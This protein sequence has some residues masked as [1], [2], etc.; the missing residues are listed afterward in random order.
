MKINATKTNLDAILHLR[1]LFLQENNFQIRYNACHQRGWTDSYIITFHE[2]AI[3]YGSVKGKN[4]LKDR[5][6]IFEFYIIPTFRNLSSISFLALLNSSGAGFIECQ[7]NEKVLTSLLY[8]MG[9]NIS[10]PV[11]LF[12]DD[13]CTS[14]APDNINFRKRRE[15]DI[16]FEHKA[17][18]AGEYVLEQNNEIV[19]S[20]GFLLHY[21]LP[22]ADLY[23]EVRED[24]RKKGLGSFLIQELKKQCYLSGRVPAARCSIENIASKATLIKA[25]LKI[26]GFMLLGSVKADG[27][28][29]L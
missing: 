11:I 2:A 29:F 5:D 7:T 20:G 6:T 21:N 1:N 4:D 3:G 13:T 22:F 28:A 17:E 12:E 9:E 8:L 10:S 25:G 16:F 15:N 26:A 19:A 18:P 14:I 24:M 27:I 23:M